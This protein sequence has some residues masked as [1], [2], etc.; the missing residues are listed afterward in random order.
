[1]S[2]RRRHPEPAIPMGGANDP[3][4]A[5]PN[6]Q[7]MASTD[8]TEVPSPPSPSPGEE[9]ESGGRVVGNLGDTQEVELSPEEQVNFASL[10]TCGRRSKTLHILDHTVVVQTLSCAD[11]LRVGLYAKEYAASVGEQRAYHVAVA[12]AAIRSINGSPIVPTLFEQPDEDAL[13]DQKVKV[14]EKMYPTVVSRIYKGALAA[15]K[16]FVELVDR[17]GKSFG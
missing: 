10:L 12:A 11:D 9:G 16:E 6:P 14:V 15:E 4:L 3:Y 13:F 1:M 2:G 5:P 17:L 8:P 7:V